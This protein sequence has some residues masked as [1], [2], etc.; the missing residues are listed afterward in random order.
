MV[1]VDRVVTGAYVPSNSI[2]S[3]PK[4]AEA[5]MNEPVETETETEATVEDKPKKRGKRRAD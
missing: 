3:E 5:P 2:K 4:E 1:F